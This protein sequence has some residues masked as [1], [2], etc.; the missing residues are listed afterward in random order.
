MKGD[1]SE[2][3]ITSRKILQSI[4]PE[5]REFYP[6]ISL[7]ILAGG[8]SSRMK[9]DKSQ[10]EF[11]GDTFLSHLIKSLSPYFNKTIISTNIQRDLDASFLQVEDIYPHSGPLA[12]IH[13]GLIN[14]SNEK[15]FVVGC[16]FPLID[17]GI[18]QKLYSVQEGSEIATAVVSG[19]IQPL[20]AIYSKKLL[21]YFE[22]LLRNS[23]HKRRSMKALFE[24]A[25]VESVDFSTEPSMKFLNINYPE[26]Y[27]LLLNSHRES[28]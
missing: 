23:D 6:D 2:Y 15:N 9:S 28:V 10:L 26:D 12:G 17:I 24:F 19:E 7:I 27:Q 25:K 22:N 16:D 18:F 20:C 13:A 3:F 11:R 8:Q 21:I 14:S 4:K 5:A 1:Y